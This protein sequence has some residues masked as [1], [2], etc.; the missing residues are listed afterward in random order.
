[1]DNFNE[2]LKG[3]KFTLYKDLATETTLGTTQL[4]TL[5]R[6]KNTMIDHDFE[7]QDRQKADL[8]DFL[9]N[10][11][12]GKGREDLQQNRAFNKVIH[13]DL[14]NAGTNSNKISGETILSITDDTR[15][16]T[17]VAVMEN[18]VIDSTVSAIWHLWCQPY[19]HPETIMFNQGK[20]QTSKLEDR[21]NKQAPLGQKINCRSRKNTFNLEIEQQWQQNQDEISNEEFVHTLNFFS[22]LQKPAK[23]S[24]NDQGHFSSNYKNLTDVEDF[25]ESENEY[26]DEH[27]LIPQTDRQFRQISKRKQISLCRHKLQNRAHGQSRRWRQATD[28]QSKLSEFEED[29]TDHQWAQL[30]NFETFIE[31]QKQEFFKHGFQ[32]PDDDNDGW[33][34]Q[35]EPGY[36]SVEEIDDS[37]D[38][39]D[40][41][42]ITAILGTFSRPKSNTNSTNASS[43]AEFTPEGAPKQAPAKPMP[44]PDFNQKFNQNFN[45]N[46]TSNHSEAEDFSCF[47]TIWEEGTT[48]LAD[49]Y[50]DKEEDDSLAD[51]YSDEEEYNSLTNGD[52]WSE[53]EPNNFED[54][55]E[56]N[57]KTPSD[58]ATCT[59]ISS[60]SVDDAQ[61][62]L[63]WHP[64]IP[65]NSHLAHKQRL[66]SPPVITG[67]QVGSVSQACLPA[68]RPKPTTTR[69]PP[70][71]RTKPCKPFYSPT[72]SATPT[73]KQ[74]FFTKSSTKPATRSQN[75]LLQ[76]G[77]LFQN[78]QKSSTH[79]WNKLWPES[80]TTYKR[81]RSS[82][83]SPKESQVRPE[84]S[85]L[86]KHWNLPSQCSIEATKSPNTKFQNTP[87]D[88]DIGDAHPVFTQY[89]SRTFSSMMYNKNT[90]KIKF[91]E[92]KLRRSSNEIRTYRTKWPKPIAHRQKNSER[93]PSWLWSPRR[94]PPTCSAGTAKTLKTFL[95]L[96]SSPP[97]RN[98]FS[99][100]RSESKSYSE[101][102]S[103][104]KHYKNKDS[105][106]PK[107]QSENKD[108]QLKSENKIMTVTT[109]EMAKADEVEKL[110]KTKNENQRGL[111]QR[112]DK[113]AKPGLQISPH[114]PFATAF[115]IFILILIFNYISL[116]HSNNHF[117]NLTIETLRDCEKPRNLQI[118][119]RFWAKMTVTKLAIPE[120][121]KSIRNSENQLDLPAKSLHR[122]IL[123]PL[124]SRSKDYSG[125]LRITFKFIHSYLPT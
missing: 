116:D 72:Y 15:T 109:N 52:T 17:Q 81:T 89:Q 35:P 50:S 30:K 75:G 88:T 20:V 36:D 65:E 70:L 51:Y 19:G 85:K 62:F 46:L 43:Y 68:Q 33:I 47:S 48:E 99:K 64:F 18:S 21:I 29:D 59:A 34:E 91:W 45:K 114:L 6:L 94:W 120:L 82:R 10:R 44:P 54:N 69:W 100:R 122:N 77:T 115:T 28:P 104:S 119:A 12:M 8:P 106:N 107:K 53:A 25:T 37:L 13:V 49:Y 103:E 61:A 22:N 57:Y 27:E 11:Q 42:Y 26:E 2:Y 105:E 24:D 112:P 123:I 108:I 98:H 80:N 63:T 97:G 58:K 90:T 60:L 92:M 117:S 39:N 16:F 110:T 32:D 74:P 67:F 118:K 66:T 101:S 79:I 4:K 76:I 124:T 55:N 41:A 7:I 23:P 73:L 84:L 111:G 38:D 87:P 125:T 5:N 14:I 95:R 113:I 121:T 96:P 78:E 56:V 86:F 83:S 71:I 102:K 93:I 9:K 31:K 3:S 40:M 1:M